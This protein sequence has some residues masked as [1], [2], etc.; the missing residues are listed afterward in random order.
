MKVLQSEIRQSTDESQFCEYS[1][2]KKLLQTNFD[3]K[4]PRVWVQASTIANALGL[5][6]DKETNRLIGMAIQSLKI[7][8]ERKKLHNK[9]YWLFPSV[10]IK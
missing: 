3:L 10:V 5:K 7:G 9:S 1:K 6:Q 2:I 4:S 8:G